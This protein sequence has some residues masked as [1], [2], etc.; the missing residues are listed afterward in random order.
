MKNQSRSWSINGL[1]GCTT[2]EG[3]RWQFVNRCKYSKAVFWRNN[4]PPA[5][6]AMKKPIGKPN[7][8]PDMHFEQFDGRCWQKMTKHILVDNWRCKTGVVDQSGQSVRLHYITT[9]KN[10]AIIIWQDDQTNKY[11][12]DPKNPTG[13][14]KILGSK[15]ILL[16]CKCTQ[17]NPS[18][19]IQFP[20]TICLC[21]D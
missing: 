5:T 9:I 20:R 4:W 10:W 11:Y 8:Y 13:S 16:V 1:Q 17:T 19:Q 2:E 14:K 15:N 7:R 12:Y 21:V 18:D 6:T 3:W